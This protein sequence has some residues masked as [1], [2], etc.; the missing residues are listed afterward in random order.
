MKRMFAV[1]ALLML[2]IALPVSASERSIVVGLST[3]VNNWNPTRTSGSIMEGMLDN[4]WEKLFEFDKDA[5]SAP[6]LA[7]SWTVIE[8]EIWEFKLRPN[9]KFT[10]GE[11]FNAE[12][13]KWS[14]ETQR[15][16]VAN[17]SR[18]WLLSIKE[19]EV[20]DDLTVR[21]HTHG[22]DPEL[23]EEL[24]WTGYMMP[25]NYA[26]KEYEGELLT[27][28][29][30]TGPYKLVEW[31]KDV[32]FVFEHNEDWWGPELDIKRIEVR[33][34]PESATRVAALLSGEVDL[35]DNPLPEDIPRLQQTQGITVEIS[36]AQR[37]VHLFMDTYR[38]NGGPDGSPGIPTNQPNPLKDPRV[39][40]AIYMAIDREEITEALHNGLAFP[41]YQP[42]LP[43]SY[44]FAQDVKF[45]EFDPVEAKRLLAEAGYPNGFDIEIKTMNNR[46][47]NDKETVLVVANHLKKIGIRATVLDY[48]MTVA[49]GA[50]RSFD[51][52][53]GLQSWGALTM[54]GMSWEGL[55]Y[56]NEETDQ[57]GSQNH[58]RF[59]DDTTNMLIDQLKRE[60]DKSQRESLFSEVATRFAETLPTIPI[61]YTTNIRAMKDHLH[62][63]TSGKEH[64]HFREMEW[65]K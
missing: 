43:T 59:V 57:W 26:S 24:T 61:Y 27:K 15:D 35:I 42:M 55:V 11:A 40:K 28:P 45:P 18:N 22:P 37:V 47:P 1:V 33:P 30:G 25:L 64:I 38:S 2:F 17:S 36:P 58:G 53:M 19:V 29:H 4:I 32:R 52:T 12:V 46:L 39:R 44:A 54:P 6:C 34:I 51:V 65:V 62:L 16:D 10:N 14:L 23:I 7:V 50:Y 41:A 48:P 20:V 56:G 31:I 5:N 21:I 60:M 8:P 49:T 3:D 13:V 9:V 63:K